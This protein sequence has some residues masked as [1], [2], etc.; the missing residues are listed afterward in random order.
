MLATNTW[1]ESTPSKDIIE[2]AT[3]PSMFVLLSQRR[4]VWLAHICRME[5]GRIPKDSGARSVGRPA[6]RFKDA[7]K[8][9]IK[10]ALIGIQS[11]ELR[12][13]WRQVV[14]RRKAEEMGNELW[15]RRESIG[16]KGHRL[17]RLYIK[18]PTPVPFL[19]E[20]VTQRSALLVTAD[21]AVRNNECHPS[22]NSIIFQDANEYNLFY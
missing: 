5:D 1:Q 7:C 17:P 3:I 21:V 20:S 19:T 8:R 10:A 15:T 14:S 16:E 9:Y 13:Y 4:L 22:H 18:L 11:W 2:R 6:V 12:N